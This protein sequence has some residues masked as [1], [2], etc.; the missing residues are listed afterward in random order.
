MRRRY[1]STILPV[2]VNDTVRENALARVD[3]VQALTRAL[4]KESPIAAVLT[5]GYLQNSGRGSR[6]RPI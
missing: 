1:P 2:A 3:A 6:V 5:D 4:P